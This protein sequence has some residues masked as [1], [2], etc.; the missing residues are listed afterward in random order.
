M[1]G[2]TKPPPV[3]AEAKG[4]PPAKAPFIQKPPSFDMKTGIMNWG[5]Y[6]QRMVI[7]QAGKLSQQG[8]SHKSHKDVR[9]NVRDGWT[10]PE[11]ATLTRADPSSKELILENVHKSASISVQVE[12]EQGSKPVPPGGNATVRPGDK[13]NVAGLDFTLEIE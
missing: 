10:S 9:W 6:I 7:G 8:F 2:A 5:N 12:G 4:N 13:I 11:F 3:P 1:P